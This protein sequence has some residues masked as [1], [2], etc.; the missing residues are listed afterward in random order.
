[1]VWFNGFAS[2]KN[3][4]IFTQSLVDALNSS[5]SLRSLTFNGCQFHSSLDVLG[6]LPRNLQSLT[7]MDSAVSPVL[8]DQCLAMC[9]GN[10]RSLTL[11]HNRTANLLFLG[12]LEINCPKLESLQYDLS[13]IS[14]QDSAVSS[15]GPAFSKLLPHGITP[16]WPSSLQRVELLYLRR[17][18]LEPAETFFNSFL[19][20]SHKLPHLRALII[21]TTV[22]LDWKA[23]VEFRDKWTARLLKVFKRYS[24]NPEPICSNTEITSSSRRTTKASSTT[25]ERKRSLVNTRSTSNRSSSHRAAEASVSSRTRKRSRITTE[26]HIDSRRSSDRITRLRKEQET[27]L[28]YSP[29]SIDIRNGNEND[30][31]EDTEKYAIQ[32]MCDVVDIRIE[33]LHPAQVQYVEN[34]FL[35]SEPSGDED[36]LD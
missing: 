21:K 16:T 2:S 30:A 27:L 36:Y 3:R 7:I 25:L 19:Q 4:D 10:L 14:D 1:M 32:G 31:T 26:N 20:H 9:G 15:A 22:D 34:D 5:P 13:S 8:L 6:A 24:P 33:N 28:N 29:P 23:R 17:W 35:D 18:G 11:K 12:A